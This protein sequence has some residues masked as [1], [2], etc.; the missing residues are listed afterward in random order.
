MTRPSAEFPRKRK[1]SMLY[2]TNTVA[3]K[4]VM[5]ITGAMLFGFTLIH[6]LGNS[7]VF[8]GPEGINAYAMSLQSLGP[9]VWVFRATLLTAFLIHVLFGIT[10]S[11]E[12]RSARSQ[13]YAVIR[14]LRTTLGARTM[15]WTGLFFIFFLV[16]HLL[17]FT[18]HVIAPE[19]SARA[20]LD[21][22]GRPDVFMMVVR[23]FRQYLFPGVYVLGVALLVLHLSHGL[24][25]LFQT[26]GLNDDRT[27]PII[28]RAGLITAIVLLIGY[29]AIPL[30][31]FTGVFAK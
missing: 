22:M 14:H 8:I 24:Q 20:H 27:L 3:K 16:F 17:H 30:A 28:K 10:L 7:S 9:L 18:F 12:N 26:T 2:I 31:I 15:I 4:L 1:R 29:T 19:F 6:L 21:V 25:S 23:S 11:L 5:A 13:K